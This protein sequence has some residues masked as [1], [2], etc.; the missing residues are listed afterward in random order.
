MQKRRTE[1]SENSKD[2][3]GKKSGGIKEEFQMKMYCRGNVARLAL[4]IGISLIAAPAMAQDA[5]WVEPITDFLDILTSG[6]GRLGGQ[7]L[8]SGLFLSVFGRLS[9]VVWIGGG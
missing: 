3:G 9:P 6:F 8:V 4:I 1:D 2:G 5:S 7:C